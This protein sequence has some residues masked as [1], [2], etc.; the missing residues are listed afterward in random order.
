M[1]LFTAKKFSLPQQVKPL[2]AKLEAHISV[3]LAV[4][5]SLIGLIIEGDSFY[6][7]FIFAAHS[8]YSFTIPLVI[9]VYLGIILGCVG[10]PMYYASLQIY[11][12]RKITEN[13]E[14]K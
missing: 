5:M 11:S 10:I 8:S 6:F 2:C 14:K 4:F 13:T 3:A 12:L 7:M 1:S 9:I